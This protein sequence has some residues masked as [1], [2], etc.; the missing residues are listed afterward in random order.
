MRWLVLAVALALSIIALRELLDRELRDASRTWVHR[1]LERGAVLALRWYDGALYAATTNGLFRTLDGGT[2]W[3]GL[4]V[5]PAE[6]RVQSAAFGESAP[7]TI[8]L[9]TAAGLLLSVDGG[10]TWREPLPVEQRV[11]LYGVGLGP[12]GHVYVA[13]EGAVL[14][15]ADGGVTWRTARDGLPPQPFV[16]FSPDPTVPQRVLAGG[17]GGLFSSAD[18]GA[19]WRPERAWSADVQVRTIIRQRSDPA[20]IYVGA[21]G[22]GV[23]GLF[24]SRDGGTTWERLGQGSLLSE[25]VNVVL[26]A[27]DALYAGTRGVADTESIG[28]VWASHDGGRTWAQ[29]K[30]KLSNTDVISLARDPGPPRALYAGTEGGI[31]FRYTLDAWWAHLV[32]WLPVVVLVEPLVLGVTLTL[33][34]LIFASLRRRTPASQA[35]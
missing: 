34:V 25:H 15:S 8:A 23:G 4:L 26:D 27:G 24:A 6:R 35:R 19:T 33:L 30:T 12:G 13:T 22:Q 5:V 2:T 14:S 16:A 1:G 9:A 7:L 29:V 18:A 17:D 28:G 3:Q 11:P 32:P 10:A 20:R 31:V 21:S